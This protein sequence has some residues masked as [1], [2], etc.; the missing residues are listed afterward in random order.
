MY[1]TDGIVLKCTPFGEAN[2]LVYVLTHDLGLILGRAQAARLTH[3]KLRFALQ[4]YSYLSISCIKGKNGWKITNAVEKN[5]FYFDAPLEARAVIAH[6]V[7]LILKMIPGE[8]PHPEIFQTVQTGFS[9]LSSIEKNNIQNFECLSVLRI[10]YHLGYVDKNAET[11]KFLADTHEWTVP[12]LELVGKSRLALVSIINKG[13]SES[14][15]T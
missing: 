15:L 3:S 7:A 4:E 11:E 2:V 9:F 5:N 10:L 13:L 8:E 6:I 14:Q 12:L 1:S